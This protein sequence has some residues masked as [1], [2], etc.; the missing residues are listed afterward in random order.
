MGRLEDYQGVLHRDT[1]G[2]GLQIHD[3]VCTKARPALM[4]DVTR[5]KYR[6]DVLKRGAEEK[7]VHYLPLVIR[8]EHLLE[9]T[10]GG[11][12]VPSWYPG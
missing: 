1:Q 9:Q 4:L 8:S 3:L 11:Y 2:G 12:G 10:R 7:D 5:N 6:H